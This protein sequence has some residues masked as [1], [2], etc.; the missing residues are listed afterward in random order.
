MSQ[1]EID[2][3]LFVEIGPGAFPVPSVGKLDFVEEETRYIGV[4]KDAKNIALPRD[5]VRRK[6]GEMG[7]IILG[8]AS[9]K[10]PLGDET[11]DIV[12]LANV[13][14][15]PKT[16]SGEL[17]KIFGESKRILKP[18]G[19]L[20][21]VENITPPISRSISRLLLAKGFGP[22]KN[23]SHKNNF[24]TLRSNQ[25]EIAKY[26]TREHV[27]YETRQPRAGFIFF[28]SKRD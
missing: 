18:D 9:E 10:L 1:N 5:M 16:H 25:G 6:V 19:E 11:A 23:S 28:V 13:A 22:S 20:I 3:Q 27:C 12:Y 14:G 26:D 17:E 15:N 24:T 21:I 2:S 7:D 4:E 8:D